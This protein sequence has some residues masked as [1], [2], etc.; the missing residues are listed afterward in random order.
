MSRGPRIRT[1][2][3]ENWQDEAVGRVR[4]EPRLLRDVLITFADDDGRWRHIPAAI[5]GHGYP[6]DDDVSPAKLK[7]W[8]GELVREGL[9]ILYTVDGVEYGCF[10]KWHLHQQ[11]NRYTPSRLP[12]CEH[13]QVVSYEQARKIRAPK[14][15]SAT[16]LSEDS[17]TSP[18]DL[19]E[20]S[21]LPRGSWSRSLSD[22]D[23]VEVARAQADGT[24]H[25]KLT[26]VVQILEAATGPNGGLLVEPASIDSMLKA[27][28][29]ADVVS[30]AHEVASMVAQ[31]S[32]RVPMA[33][34]V[35]GS[36]LRRQYATNVRQLPQRQ[37]PQAPRL[38]NSRDTARFKGL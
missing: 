9:V 32:N 26:E 16:D 28:P 34:S 11:I 22:P 8:T 3:P 25:P 37:Q 15:N 1:L 36:V 7:R 30:A 38:T 10:P 12:A 31:G 14:P 24:L 5:I 2:K 17:R 29:E 33:G 4:R 20:S 6:W 27:H 18:V 13:E 23:Q 21:Q 19:N 35:L